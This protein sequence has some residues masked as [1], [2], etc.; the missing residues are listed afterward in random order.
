MVTLIRSN[1]EVA[2]DPAAIAAST[3]ACSCGARTVT[4]VGSIR[5]V[6]FVAGVAV[7]GAFS[8]RRRAGRETA[9]NRRCLGGSS[10]TIP[11]Q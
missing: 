2:A 7:S 1:N 10:S 11:A 4:D 3:H 6:G 5:G 8:D 9:A